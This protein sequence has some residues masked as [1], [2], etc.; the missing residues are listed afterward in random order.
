MAIGSA[1][2][3][4]AI[5]GVD[6]SLPCVDGEQLL[7]RTVRGAVLREG[8]VSFHWII[9][10]LLH[11]GVS[12]SSE[13]FLLVWLATGKN[14]RCGLCRPCPDASKVTTFASTS[15]NFRQRTCRSRRSY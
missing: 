8:S 3:P 14:G 12:R 10:S 11:R 7:S 15:D 1:V 2:R 5:G 4:N 13:K 6:A 9:W